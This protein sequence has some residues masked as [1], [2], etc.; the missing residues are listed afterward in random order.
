MDL[1]NVVFGEVTLESFEDF[2]K[3]EAVGRG[4]VDI[5]ILNSKLL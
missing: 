2:K 4:L 5:R 1:K 3:L